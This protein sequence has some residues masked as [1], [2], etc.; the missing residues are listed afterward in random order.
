MT[1]DKNRNEMDPILQAKYSF[2]TT[3]SGRTI[4][5]GN[6]RKTKAEKIRG[7]IKREA[8]RAKRIRQIYRAHVGH[9]D[10]E[11][12]PNCPECKLALANRTERD[13]YYKKVWEITEASFKKHYNV[14]NP[15]GVQRGTEW[16]LDHRFSIAEGFR[17]NIEP[18]IIGSH[19]NLQMLDSATNIKKK[20]ACWVSAE[21]LTQQF[22]AS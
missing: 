18:D 7:E 11:K 10:P 6:K 5:I 8:S 9:R 13:I 17:Q 20:D 21:E 2:R 14:I 15:D 3:K 16:H 22:K 1:D 4:A 19:H 12:T